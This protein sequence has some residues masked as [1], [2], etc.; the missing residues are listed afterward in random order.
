MDVTA[1]GSASSELVHPATRRERIETIALTIYSVNEG[2]YGIGAEKCFIGQQCISLCISL[3]RGC[4][5]SE[6]M[7]DGKH[8]IR[9][10]LCSQN[11]LKTCGKPIF[12]SVLLDCLNPHFPA[13]ITDGTS[14]CLPDS[15]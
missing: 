2:L 8:F 6:D 10:A 13:F 4:R 14:I 1:N 12:V 11:R 15:E 7:D 3:P 5:N 9:H